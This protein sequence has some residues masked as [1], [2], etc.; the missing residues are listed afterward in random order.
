MKCVTDA[1]WSKVLTHFYQT[2]SLTNFTWWVKFWTV[3]TAV[4]LVWLC[5]ALYWVT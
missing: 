2:T 4:L 3:L 1:N 5:V